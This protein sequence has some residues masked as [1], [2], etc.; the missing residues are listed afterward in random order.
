[1]TADLRARARKILPST[2]IQYLV[3]VKRTMRVQR[4]RTEATRIRS[5]ALPPVELV[6]MTMALFV[7]YQ[8][9]AETETEVRYR[10]GTSETEPSRELVIEKNGMAGTVA[11]GKTDPLV[12]KVVGR[13]L[14][15]KGND[16]NWPGG[17]G[18]Q[19]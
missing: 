7:I 17:G 16:P 5:A 2:I 13:V 11:D 14:A 9:A 3:A 1:M 8:K 18:I 4:R 10:F 12:L 19:A 6:E 15:R